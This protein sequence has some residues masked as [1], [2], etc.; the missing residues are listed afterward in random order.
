MPSVKRNIPLY[1]TIKTKGDDAQKEVKS[2]V[3]TPKDKLSTVVSMTIGDYTGT[4]KDCALSILPLR[5]QG[6]PN[7]CLSGPWQYCNILYLE[8]DE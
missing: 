1:C 2:V 6:F 4:D 8:A 7:L 5:E 3:E